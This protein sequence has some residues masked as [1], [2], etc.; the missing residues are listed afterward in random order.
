MLSRR[1]NRLLRRTIRSP[2]AAQKRLRCPLNTKKAGAS[3]CASVP[4]FWGGASGF[5]VVYP[6]FITYWTAAR[7]L[8]FLLSPLAF[9][10][11]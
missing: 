2:K 4:I 3:K 1:R 10:Q 6:M 11:A 9:G 7:A 5:G 8:P